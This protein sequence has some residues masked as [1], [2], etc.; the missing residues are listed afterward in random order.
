MALEL[1]AD[2]VVRGAGAMGMAFVDALLSE[3]DCKVIM[4]DKHSQPGGHWNDAYPFVRLHQ[5][6]KYYGVNSKKLERSDDPLELASRSEILAY[7]EA[8]M[9]KFI[10]SGRVTFYPRCV[11]EDLSSRAFHS[12]LEPDRSYQ[13]C[14]RAKLVDA[15]YMNVV[16]PSISNPQQAG[17]F[18]VGED[19]DLVPLNALTTIGGARPMYVVIGAGKTGMD[20]VLY[21]LNS[22]VEPERIQWIMPRDSWLLIRE[23][24]RRSWRPAAAVQVRHRERDRAGAAAANQADCTNGPSEMPPQRQSRAGEGHSGNLRWYVVR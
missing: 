1:D 15:S 7:F 24:M 10:A 2:Y 21:L 5:P 22:S 17:R 6:S 8:V 23:A 12:L 4:V 16:V 13:V 3:K 9:D 14:Q 18:S 20:A 11:Y 19:V